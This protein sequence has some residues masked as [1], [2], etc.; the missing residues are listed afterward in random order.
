MATDGGR[1]APSVEE[2]LFDPVA[3]RLFDF[4]QAVGLLEALA[5]AAGAAQ[6]GV[7]EGGEPSREAVRFASTVRLNFPTSDIAQISPPAGAQAAMTVNFLGLAGA[8]GPLPTP[9]AEI[10]LRRA[11]VG[12]TAARDFLDIFNHRLVSLVYR[13][14]KRHRISLGAASPLDDDAARYLFALI[15]LGT[16]GLRDRVPALP[17]RALLFHAGLFS[18]EIRPIGGLVAILR[19]H[20]GVPVEGVP[21]VGGFYPIEASH[22]TAIGPSGKNRRLGQDAVLGSRYWDPAACTEIRVGPLDVDDY[23]RFLPGSPGVPAGDRLAPLLALARFYA[24]ETTDVRIRLV[25]RPAAAKRRGRHAKPQRSRTQTLGERPRLGYTAWVG[26]AFDQ[27]EVVL[28]GA[29]LRGALATR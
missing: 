4:F 8:H 3:G 22:R 18:R 2:Q 11:V 27:R 7:G 23:L 29:A 24:G 14:R 15:G 21:L 25:L 20:F 1:K 28:G 6:A 17:D 26:R 5:R 13:I 10:V 16:A 9:F 19:C 12:D